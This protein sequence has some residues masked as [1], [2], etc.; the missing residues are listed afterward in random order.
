MS[1]PALCSRRPLTRRP[2]VLFALVC[3]ASILACEE[4]PAPVPAPTGIEIVSGDAQYTL[5]G[6]EL[7]E[8]VVVQVTDENGDPASGVEVRFQITAGGGSLSR[9]SAG[10]SGN[11]QTSVRWTVGPATGANTLRISVAEN[12]SISATAGATSA[13]YYCPEEDPT[14]VQK[15][16]DA[17]DLV[18]LTRS[19]SLTQE[20]GEAL[21]GLVRFELN[22]IDLEFLGTSLRNYDED[23]FD[24]VVRD[25]AFSA[26]G[27]LFISWNNIRNEVMKV[28]SDGVATHFAALPT[29]LDN[30]EGAEIAMTPGGVLVG[31]D[32]V[33]PFV[34]TCRDTVFRYPDATF[35]GAGRDAAN[36]DAVAVDP[37]TDDLYFIYKADR[38]LRR[39]PLNGVGQEAPT[40]EIVTLPIAESDGARGMAVDTDGSLYILVDSTTTRAIIKVSGGV[41]TVEFDFFSRGAGD[42]AGIQSDLAIDRQ[43]HFLYTLDTKN[44]VLLLYAIGTQQFA[45]LVSSADPEAASSVGLYGERVG[46]DV[47]P[48]P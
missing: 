42:A 34:V 13:D 11:G 40:E 48:G 38:T 4:D 19:S 43:Y 36:T 7:E 12:S 33:G 26:N 44:D 14:F 16:N 31:C 8:P 29:S 20:A 15:F 6:T 21:A 28:A 32:R 46:L 3:A 22:T 9:S 25:C 17:H 24:N 45:E 35:S 37:N 39:I 41:R 2:G 1:I 47:L 27:D 30:S 18:L 10:T 5:K 23:V